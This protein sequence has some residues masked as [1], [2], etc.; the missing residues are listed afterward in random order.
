M[1]QESPCSEFFSE[2]KGKDASAN[3]IGFPTHFLIFID[4]LGRAWHIE[5]Q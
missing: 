3:R 1:K 4:T 5:V 2:M